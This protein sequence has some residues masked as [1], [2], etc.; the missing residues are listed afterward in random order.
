MAIQST[1]TE[2]DISERDAEVIHIQ[3][4]DLSAYVNTH[5]SSKKP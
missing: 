5:L 1:Q 2:M 4:E 3:I